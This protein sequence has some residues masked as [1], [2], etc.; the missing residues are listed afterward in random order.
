MTMLEMRMVVAARRSEGRVAHIFV[1]ARAAQ[2][3]DSVILFEQVGV[4][5][6]DGETAEGLERDGARGRGIGDLAE[7]LPGIGVVGGLLPLEEEGKDHRAGG[8]D[9]VPGPG[10]GPGPVRSASGPIAPP[11]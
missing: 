11:A 3:C 8:I 9:I 6:D 2:G 7:E 1:E 10:R 4:E 5:L